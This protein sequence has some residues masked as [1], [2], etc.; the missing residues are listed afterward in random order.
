MELND[1]ELKLIRSYL[2]AR[3]MYINSPSIWKPWMVS[4]LERIEAELRN[5]T[6]ND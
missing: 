6:T 1:Q 5:R 4:F 3:S 2:W